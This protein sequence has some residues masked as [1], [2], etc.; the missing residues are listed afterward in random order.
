V[1]KNGFRRF[2]GL[3]KATTPNEPDELDVE[4]AKGGTHSTGLFAPLKTQSD[5]A[6]VRVVSVDE[7]RE[8]VSDSVGEFSVANSKRAVES[9]RSRSGY[10]WVSQVS[11]EKRAAWADFVDQSF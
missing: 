6:P 2:L 9:S 8:L 11:R 4:P 10:R 3:S 7:K 1:A 5:A